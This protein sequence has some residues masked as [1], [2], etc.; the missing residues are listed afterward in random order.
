MSQAAWNVR[1]QQQEPES[2]SPRLLADPHAASHPHPGGAGR[3]PNPGWGVVCADGFLPRRRG[4]RGWGLRGPQA[5][6]EDLGS[7]ALAL[8]GA[9]GLVS[10]P[11]PTGPLLL[12]GHFLLE[13]GAGQQPVAAPQPPRPRQSEGEGTPGGEGLGRG[14]SAAHAPHLAAPAPPSPRGP[15]CPQ[16]RAPQTDLRLRWGQ[17]HSGR[18]LSA[19]ALRPGAR[20]GSGCTQAPPGSRCPAPA[21]PGCADTLPPGRRE[22]RT[23]EERQMGGRGGGGG[24]EGGPRANTNQLEK[25]ERGQAR[26]ARRLVFPE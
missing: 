21:L 19:E 3:G 13:T 14:C 17:V 5:L 20:G 9:S 2:A 8:G 4:R 25:Q 1:P 10:S 16:R 22:R 6:E 24:G 15:A 26:A 18:N 12:C 7:Q 11:A 23:E